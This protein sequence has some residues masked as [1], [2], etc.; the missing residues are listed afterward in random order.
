MLDYVAV[1][2]SGGLILFEKYFVPQAEKTSLK[3][4]T[5]Q[6]INDTFLSNKDTD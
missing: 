5:Q 2:H 6:F 3:N 4:L 1:L